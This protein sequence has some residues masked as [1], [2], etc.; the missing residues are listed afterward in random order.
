MLRFNY[1]FGPMLVSAIAESQICG[2]PTRARTWDLRINSPS[3]LKVISLHY[4]LPTASAHPRHR[5]RMQCNAGVCKTALLR[6]C[7]Q[8]PIDQCVLLLPCCETSLPKTRARVLRSVGKPPHS[9]AAHES[10]DKPLAFRAQR[11]PWF[12]VLGLAK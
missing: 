1:S 6:F 9:N 8:V 12:V 5:S 7:I 11:T 2:S 10:R 3:L 4:Q